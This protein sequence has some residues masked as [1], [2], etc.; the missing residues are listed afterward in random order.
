VATGDLN[1]D[2][3][4]DLVVVAGAGLDIEINQRDGSFNSTI[5]ASE[6]GGYIQQVQ[7]ADIDEDGRADIV[8]CSYFGV[9]FFPDHG[10]APSF[11]SP[12]TIPPYWTDDAGMPGSCLALIVSDLDQ[13]GNPDVVDAELDLVDEGE[14]GHVVIHWGLGDGGF[15]VLTAYVADE[16]GQFGTPDINGDGRP[17]LVWVT[18]T[19]V[20]AKTNLGNRNFGFE[21]DVGTYPYTEW[22][23]HLAIADLNGDGLPDAVTSGGLVCSNDAGG[24][25]AF[26]FL[27]DG[28][29][30]FTLGTVLPVETPVAGGVTVWSRQ[31]DWLPSVVVGDACDNNVLVY[32][33]LTPDAGD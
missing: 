15:P 16:P 12:I 7:I 18:D 14:P 4:I 3:W 27:N 23:N 8:V 21:V 22:N 2:G 25:F 9:L 5:I 20:A 29:G 28:C 24:P 31:G 11:G 30:G 32:P 6:M 13:D 26:V 1:G 33:N 19:G 17:D 10:G